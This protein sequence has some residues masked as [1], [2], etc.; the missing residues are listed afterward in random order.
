VRELLLA[1]GW[2]RAGILGEIAAQLNVSVATICRDRQ[3]LE[4]W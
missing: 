1:C 4:R 3:A 2:K